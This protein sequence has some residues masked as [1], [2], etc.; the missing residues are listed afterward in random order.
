VKT[1]SV[2]EDWQKR[3]HFRQEAEWVGEMIQE[4]AKWWLELEEKIKRLDTK[5]AEM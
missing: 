5:I 2:I 3:A 4:D 1:V